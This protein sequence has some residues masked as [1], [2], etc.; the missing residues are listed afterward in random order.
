MKRR[1]KN[2]FGV[3][4]MKKRRPSPRMIAIRVW[5]LVKETILSMIPERFTR[6][7]KP[8]AARQSSL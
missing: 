2:S 4:T 6:P 1:L 7:P 3:R 5:L 8:K